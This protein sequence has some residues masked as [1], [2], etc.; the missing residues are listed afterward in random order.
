MIPHALDFS[1]LA[2]LIWRI[3]KVGHRLDLSVLLPRP[4]FAINVSEVSEN[5]Y[6]PPITARDISS[7]Y[8][9]C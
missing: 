7:E 9:K 1:M 2:A 5:G 6:S 3:L 4:Y 8:A